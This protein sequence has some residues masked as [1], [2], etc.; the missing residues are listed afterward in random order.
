VSPQQYLQ[1]KKSEV[2]RD[3]CQRDKCTFIDKGGAVPTV[4]VK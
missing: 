3:V 2:E 1:L 4:Q